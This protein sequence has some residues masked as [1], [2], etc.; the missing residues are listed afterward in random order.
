[1]DNQLLIERR[2]WQ[3]RRFYIGIGIV[4]VI[5]AGFILYVNSLDL[6][7]YAWGYAHKPVFEKALEAATNNEEVI[8][9]LGT[10]EP[11]GKMTIAEGEIALNKVG[12]TATITIKGNQKK[13]KMDLKVHRFKDTWVYDYVNIRIKQPKQTI[14]VQVPEPVIINPKHR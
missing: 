7:S 1:M 14:P 2:F 6:Q 5:I 11:I 3:S 8:A 13:G 9:Q 10:L 4:A 12:F